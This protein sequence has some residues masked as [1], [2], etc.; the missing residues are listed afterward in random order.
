LLAT[1]AKLASLAGEHHQACCCI[2]LSAVAGMCTVK[3]SRVASCCMLLVAT[4]FFPHTKFTVEQRWACKFARQLRACLPHEASS[5]AIFIGEGD[6][7]PARGSVMYVVAEVW[8][9][10]VELVPATVCLSPQ[11]ATGA[12]GPLELHLDLPL[13]FPTSVDVI[14]S[15]CRRCLAG[16]SFRISVFDLKWDLR[17]SQRFGGMHVGSSF[18]CCVN[19]LC[20]GRGQIFNCKT[21]LKLA[22]ASNTYPA[23]RCSLGGFRSEATVLKTGRKVSADVG[24]PPKRH[25]GGLPPEFS[26]RAMDFSGSEDEEV[27]NVRLA[28]LRVGSWGH[29]RSLLQR[30]VV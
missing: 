30:C 13:S 16:S 29:A 26:S 11:A 25:R 18:W 17:S 2:V 5:V 10:A 15:Y 3:L 4:R 9:F 24:R 27:S 20:F 23:F 22:L 28:H 19:D 14:A 7:R 1:P 12:I 8:K 21:S 6:S